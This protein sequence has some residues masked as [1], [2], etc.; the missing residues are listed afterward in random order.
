MADLSNELVRRGH[1]VYAVLRPRSP[2]FARLNELDQEWISTLPLRN[3]LDVTSANKLARFVKQHQVEIIHAHMARDYSLAAYAARRNPSAKLILTR[4][5]LFRLNRWHR[6]LLARA[7]RVIAVSDAVAG[8]LRSQNLF[9]SSR[10]S[11]VRNGVDVEALAAVCG[12][13][14][15]GEYRR[16]LDLPEN[17]LLV[18]TVGQLNPLKGHEVFLRAAALVIE[19]LPQARFV[20]AGA[21]V[22]A[23]GETIASLTRLIGE[24]GLQ[25]HV[26]L[27]GEVENVSSVLAPLDVFVSASRAESF[28][29]AI[30]EAMACSLPVVATDTEG[31]REVIEENQ[32]GLI[33]PIDEPEHLAA[34]IIT[35]LADV[36]LRMQMG[37]QGYVRAREQFGLK[38][39]VD[40]IEMIYQ[41]SS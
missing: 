33:V 27:L 18:G 35:L 23:A 10:I 11:V 30:V 5:V 24:L 8:Q 20:I 1:D 3:A 17:S 40:N 31:A 15:R 9:P 13:T 7:A 38:R 28:G 39:M 36:Q 4:H 6:R 12:A 25:S 22:S 14:D 19:S 34:S 21:D 16:N 2:L 41:E 32:T 29:L 26:R 37:H